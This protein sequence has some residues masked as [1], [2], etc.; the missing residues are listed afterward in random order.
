MYRYENSKSWLE[1]QESRVFLINRKKLTL[2]PGMYESGPD[3]VGV[4]AS[5]RNNDMAL[6]DL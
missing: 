6:H 1:F 4:K 5:L 3:Q 2:I